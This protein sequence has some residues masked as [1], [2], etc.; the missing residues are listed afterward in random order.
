MNA[1]RPKLK[2]PFQTI[3]IVIELASITVLILM[4]IHLIL[5]FANLPDSVPSH[6]NAA[7]EPDNYSGKGF[8]WFL[9]ALATVMYIGLF[10]LNRFPH[11]HNYKVNITEENTLKQYRFSTRILRIVNF[12][13]A[14]ILAYINYQIIIG[15]QN[16]ASDLGVGFLITVVGV[17]VL[18]P[19]FIYVYQQKLKK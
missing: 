14:L 13:C 4:W 6:F 17:S 10:I 8:L 15:A 19:V 5:E 18:L 11:L 1:E 3:D 12:L 2:I 16:N 7:G 9:P